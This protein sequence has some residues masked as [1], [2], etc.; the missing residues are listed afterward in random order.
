MTGNLRINCIPA[1]K[2]PSLLWD[3]S[4]GGCRVFSTTV[5]PVTCVALL[6]L[7]NVSCSWERCGIEI[8]WLRGARDKSFRIWGLY[9]SF[10]AFFFM[11]IMVGGITGIEL[12]PSSNLRFFFMI[13]SWR[14]WSKE[15]TRGCWKL[16][17][18]CSFTSTHPVLNGFLIGSAKLRISMPHRSSVHE[19]AWHVFP[20]TK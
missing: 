2:S 7:Q 13:P 9:D 18:A 15:P 16:F 8:N 14:V 1:K 19:E 10:H 5:F 3:V 17:F 20:K 6:L 12:L 11:I 4:Q